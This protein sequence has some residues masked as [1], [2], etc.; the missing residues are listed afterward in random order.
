MDVTNLEIP[1]T[2]FD[3]QYLFRVSPRSYIEEIDNETLGHLVFGI[4]TEY[5]ESALMAWDT[6]VNQ[7]PLTYII[8]YDTKTIGG[9]QRLTN[10]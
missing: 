6:A 1:R 10:T 4:N 2:I 8:D 9:T 7:A 3:P 5:L